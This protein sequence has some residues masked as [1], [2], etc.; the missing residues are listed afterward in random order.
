MANT[1]ISLL[2][3]LTGANVAPATDIIPIVDTSATETK[4]ITVSELLIG[5]GVTATAAELNILDGV[6]ATTAEINQLDGV[7]LSGNNTGDNAVNSNYSGLAAEIDAEEAAR[8]AADSALST[9]ISN[10]ASTRSSADSSLQTNID[11]K[12]TKNAD[13]TGATKTKITYDAKGLVTSGADATTAD[14]A[15][16][17]NK[18]YVTDADLV[19][20]GNLSGTNSGDNA[21]NSLYSGLVSNATHTGEVTGSG[22]LTVDKTA[23]TNKTAVTPATD[24]YILISDTS[25]S[26]NLKKALISGLPS[27]GGGSAQVVAASLSSTQ[28]NYAISGLSTSSGVPT[29]LY[30]TPTTS[31][32]FQSLNLTGV[33]DGKTIIIVNSTVYNSASARAFI[34]ENNNGASGTKFLYTYNGV[35]MIVIPGGVSTFIFTDGYLRLVNSTCFGDSPNACFDYFDDLLWAT[36]TSG[37]MLPALKFGSGGTSSIGVNTTF[38]VPTDICPMGVLGISTGSASAVGSLILQ[39]QH[40]LQGGRGFATF[41][42]RATSDTTLSTGSD[43]WFDFIGFQNGDGSSVSNG[44]YWK[45]DAATATNWFP[46]TNLNGTES[47]VTGEGPTVNVN[48]MPYLGIF[49]NGDWTRAEYF[50]STDG[51]TWTWCATAIT[52]NIPTASNRLFSVG[53]SRR[54]TAGTATRILAIDLLAYTYR[55]LRTV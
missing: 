33:E 27:G 24:D 34:I 46:A 10:E 38:V 8:V 53:A 17:A 23:I 6:T 49:I 36:V 19:D 55:A 41:L 44:V 22:A 28:T 25:D 43:T 12:V 15:D 11:N 16:S 48:Q 42:G 2:T 32:T 3:A 39:Q 40:I 4:K 50:Y 54:R 21:V 20:I 52:T 51:I 5:M 35:P 31:F 47:T 13:I 1:K 7:T 14:I 9:L 45:Y 30:V 18:R 29:I 26:G 37:S